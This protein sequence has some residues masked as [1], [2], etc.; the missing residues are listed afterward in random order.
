[1]H[2]RR[3]PSPPCSAVPTAAPPRTAPGGPARL[4]HRSVPFP[5]AYS[6]HVSADGQMQPVPFPPDALLGS[7]IPRHA[8]QLHSLAHGEVVCAVTISN[9]TRHVYTGGKGCVKVW[10]VGQPGA[11]TAV[12]QLDCLVRG[13]GGG[14]WAPGSRGRTGGGARGGP[15]RDGAGTG[16]GSGT[17][18]P[19][20]NAGLPAR[21][22]GPR[23]PPVPPRPAVPEGLRAAG[24]GLTGSP[25][26]RRTATTTSAPASCSPT[27]AA[28]KLGFRLAHRSSRAL[29][30]AHEAP[31]SPEGTA[32]HRA[33]LALREPR[34]SAGSVAGSRA[35]SAPLAS[36]EPPTRRRS[37]SARPPPLE[38]AAHLVKPTPA[39]PFAAD[40]DGRCGAAGRSEGSGAGRSAPGG[41]RPR[42]GILAWQLCSEP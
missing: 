4:R 24:K 28:A 25:P 26:R 9:S 31:R 7:G 36:T 38:A 10:D 37:R 6:F 34:P 19:G 39:P 18:P 40:P 8:R 2:G 30:S 29:R 21:G 20:P 23:R 16:P 1:M 17:S 3:R 41:G 42:G 33:H 12:A 35:A 5:S 11:K 15:G 13:P 14:R 32:A 27:A 22:P